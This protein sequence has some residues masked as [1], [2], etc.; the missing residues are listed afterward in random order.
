METIGDDES[1]AIVSGERTK[2]LTTNSDSEEFSM[3]KIGRSSS[4]LHRTHSL[5]TLLVIM[6]LLAADLSLGGGCKLAA[7]AVSKAG[8]DVVKAGSHFGD[9]ALKQGVGA[10]D[11]V[12]RAGSSSG[13]AAIVAGAGA[14]AVGRL[15]KH[16]SWSA[17]ATFDED[18]KSDGGVLKFGLYET[19]SKKSVSANGKITVQSYLRKDDINPIH[20]EEFSFSTTDFVNG[21][22]TKRSATPWN[23]W[24]GVEE[25]FWVGIAIETNGMAV[26]ITGEQA[27]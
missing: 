2:T 18:P 25:D 27:P 1:Q 3:S 8:D 12:A 16:P 5:V 7:K 14:R 19:S 20:V 21:T 6:L 4:P 17:W 9:D 10:G 23:D 22:V 11:D 26:P 15:T 24:A 13:N